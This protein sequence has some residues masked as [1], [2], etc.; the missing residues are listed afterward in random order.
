M[1]GNEAILI[2]I[3]SN[4]HLIS[5][6]LWELLYSPDFQFIAASPRF[7]M[8]RTIDDNISHAGQKEE[9]SAGPLRILFMACS[10]DGTEPLLDYEKEEEIVLGAVAELKRKKELEIDMAEGGTLKELKEM[11]ARKDYHLVH[12]SGHGYYDGRTNTGYLCMENEW[13]TEKRVSAKELAEILIG[14]S[15]VRLLFLSAC[16]SV[17][18]DIPNTGLARSLMANGLPVV[19]G[20]KQTI[21][22]YAASSLAGSFYRHLTLKRSVA[23]ALQL[24]RSEFA[25]DH[26]GNFQWAIPAIF[27][28][29]DNTSIS[30]VDWAKPSLPIK[31]RESSVILYGRVKHLKVG[32]R[33][34]RREIREYLEMLRKERPSAICITGA[35]GIGKSTLSSKLTDRLHKSG[36]MV[37]PLYGELTPDT[38]IQGTLNS[39]VSQN[40]WEHLD[41]LKKLSDYNEQLFYIMS[42]VSGIKETIYLLDNFEDNL[43]QSAEFK[44]FKNPF[45]EETFKTLQEQLPHTLSKMMITCRYSIPKIPEELLLQKPL[46]E[47]SEGEVRKL[48]IFNADYAGISLKQIKEV[49][50]TIGGNP[51][52]LEEL[53]KLFKRK[54][55]SWDILQEKLEMVKKEMREFTIFEQLYNFLSPEEQSFFRK[56]SVY[57]GPVHVDGI[58]LMEPDEARIKFYLNK[59]L[60]YSLI[61]KYEDPIRDREYYQVHPLNRGHIRAEWWKKGEEERAHREAANYYFPSGD[62]DFNLG[63]LI[64]AV[65]HLR[66][67]KEY[68]RSRFGNRLC[69]TDNFKRFLG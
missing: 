35:G 7:R 57:L 3:Q 24:A 10:P 13:G 53:G 2:N 67:G 32:F 20:M 55:I 17:R 54:D 51:K 16:Q 44:D 26:K 69:R 66:S 40:E 43:K 19:I 37:I 45:W 62:N 47:M 46:Q 49:Y 4:D 31:D 59:L 28:R 58:K 52:A 34:R 9:L 1:A 11:L 60:D 39:L 22:D 68:N 65:Y 5:Q 8:I 42:N 21:G 6:L 48:V 56:V 50:R 63:S 25:K 30:I 38:F 27:C 64:K 61:Q 18:E 14:C 41:R 15:S 23:Q 33:G 12:L 29:S 36:Y